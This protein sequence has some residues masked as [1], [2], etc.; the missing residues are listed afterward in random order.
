MD[1]KEIAKNVLILVSKGY[2]SDYGD[3]DYFY[4]AEESDIDRAYEMK[5]ELQAYGEIAFR[6]KYGL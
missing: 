5:D 4:D 6:E 3:T 2:V 1:D